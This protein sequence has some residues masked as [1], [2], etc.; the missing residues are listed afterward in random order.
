[1]SGIC[2]LLSEG[3]VELR[4]RCKT[5]DNKISYEC[6]WAL[7]DFFPSMVFTELV[8]NSGDQNV[9]TND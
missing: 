8:Y 2:L 6:K 7:T 3:E 9:L 5:V 4:L 1:M